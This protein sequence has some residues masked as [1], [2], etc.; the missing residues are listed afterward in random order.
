[1]DGETE[2]RAGVGGSRGRWTRA[3]PRPWPEPRPQ[4]GRSE[5]AQ[6]PGQP[7]CKLGL[8][9]EHGGCAGTGHGRNDPGVVPASP[10]APP[11]AGAL[12]CSPA[13]KHLPQVAPGGRSAPCTCLGPT[14]PGCVLPPGLWPPSATCHLCRLPPA[15]CRPQTRAGMLSRRRATCSGSVGPGAGGLA[16]REMGDRRQPSPGACTP[17]GRT[18]RV[19][20]PE[21]RAAT[22]EL[23]CASSPGESTA[24]HG[25]IPGHL[26][27][28]TQLVVNTQCANWTTETEGVFAYPELVS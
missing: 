23:G 24:K 7:W 9:V 25:F 16:F 18:R 15:T 3:D 2:G 28:P 14:H 17:W 4:G 5:A 11:G 13:A 19:C 1:M 10:P 12:S 21:P 8:P 20:P 6:G 27:E 26:L 22:V